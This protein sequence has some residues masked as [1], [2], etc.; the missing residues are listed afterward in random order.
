MGAEEF[1]CDRCIAS[2]D[3]V[4]E[5]GLDLLAS[6]FINEWVEADDVCASLDLERLLGE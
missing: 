1:A 4:V 2:Q 5:L 6:Y 3:Y